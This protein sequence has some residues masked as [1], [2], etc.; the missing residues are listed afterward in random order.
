ME[1]TLTEAP[2]PLLSESID[3]LIRLDAPQGSA[4]LGD[5]VAR[6]DGTA[7]ANYTGPVGVTAYEQTITLCVPEDE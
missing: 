5:F 1:L 4:T 6:R 2:D 3:L 7:F